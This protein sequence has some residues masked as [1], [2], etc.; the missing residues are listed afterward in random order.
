MNIFPG[1]AGSFVRFSPGNCGGFYFKKSKNVGSSADIANFGV[2]FGRVTLMWA[3]VVF[4]LVESMNP[5]PRIRMN[6]FGYR[7]YLI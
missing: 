4:M 2:S 3:G 7:S 6:S 5:L 1:V